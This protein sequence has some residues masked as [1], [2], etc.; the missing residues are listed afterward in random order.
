MRI[1]AGGVGE[2]GDEAVTIEKT[3]ILITYQQ[4]MSPSQV[5]VCLAEP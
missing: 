1:E 3:D 5:G 4:K 2:A